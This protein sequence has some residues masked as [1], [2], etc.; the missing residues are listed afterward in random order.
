MQWDSES[1]V[2]DQT[3]APPSQPD[4][5]TVVMCLLPKAITET[6]PSLHAR[7]LTD[8]PTRRTQCTTQ[9]SDSTCCNSPCMSG[10]CSRIRRHCQ[11]Q[12]TE[13]RPCLRTPH[14]RRCLHLAHNGHKKSNGERWYSQ[15]SKQ[16][17]VPGCRQA[18]SKRASPF[19]A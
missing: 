4:Y 16:R 11:H 18:A 5:S 10:K 13:R 2:A 17:R 7:T 14:I 6:T 12:T 9:R 8:S 3:N 19:L 1:E 15:H